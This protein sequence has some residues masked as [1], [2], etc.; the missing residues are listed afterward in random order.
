MRINSFSYGPTFSGHTRISE[1]T[2][3]AG[4]G[5]KFATKHGIS[6]DETKGRTFATSN[7]Y[8][9]VDK[10]DL[11]VALRPKKLATKHGISVDVTK[12]EQFATSNMYHG[13]ASGGKSFLA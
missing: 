2:T 7:M 12:G 5:E 10:G 3:E 13:D 11:Y 4:G 6:V 8:H 9:G 1:D